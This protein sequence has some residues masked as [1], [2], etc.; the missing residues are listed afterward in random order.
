MVRTRSMS[1]SGIF[2]SALSLA[3]AVAACT[4]PG[5]SPSLKPGAP[6]DAMMDHSPSPS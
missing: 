5:A 6:S 1:R 3:G 2:I 4:A